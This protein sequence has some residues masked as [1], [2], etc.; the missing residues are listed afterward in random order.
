M[1]GHLGT[2]RA[3]RWTGSAQEMQELAQA[4]STL[5]SYHVVRVSD[6]GNL[7]GDLPAHAGHYV[8]VIFDADRSPIYAGS[9]GASR[10]SQGAPLIL[11]LGQ[12]CRGKWWWPQAA[13]IAWQPFPDALSARVE[14]GRIGRALKPPYVERLPCPH[15]R[16]TTASCPECTRARQGKYRAADPERA[17]QN[18]ERYRERRSEA[19]HESQRQ[20]ARRCRARR[21][22]GPEQGGLW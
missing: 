11:R 5:P 9:V 7:S 18:V 21:H 15:G 13:L 6:D 1:S 3:G 22:L 12:H 19:Y 8:Y 20:S 10:G 17:R 4:I 14:E 2:I 16:S